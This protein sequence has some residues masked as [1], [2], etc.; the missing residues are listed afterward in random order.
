MNSLKREATRG[1]IIVTV[2]TVEMASIRFGG[3]FCVNGQALLREALRLEVEQ[4]FG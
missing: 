3:R 2:E 1:V 4:L